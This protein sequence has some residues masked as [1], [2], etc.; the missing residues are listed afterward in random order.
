VARRFF[1]GNVN[2]VIYQIEGNGGDIIPQQH[3]M[4]L[5]EFKSTST[6]HI[7]LQGKVKRTMH[8]K[9][10]EEQVFSLEQKVQSDFG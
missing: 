10:K 4:T 9:R 2:I 6:S 1:S 5:K 7:N 8:N 3:K